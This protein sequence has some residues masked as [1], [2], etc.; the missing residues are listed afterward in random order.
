MALVVGVLGP[1]TIEND[2]DPVGKLPKK[3]RALLAYLADH[4]GR[5]VSRERLAD[6]LWPYQASDQARHS[7]RNCLLELRKELGPSATRHLNADFSTCSLDAADVDLD[8]FERLS[9]SVQRAELQAAADLYRGELLADFVIDSEPFQEWLAVERDRTLELVC[10]ILQRLIAAQDA[11]GLHDAAIRSARRLVAFDQLSEVGQRALI[12]AYARAGRRPE[13]LRQY[14]SCIE[15]LKRELGVAPDAETQ[16]LANEITRSGNAVVPPVPGR[17][18]PPVAGEIAAA[19]EPVPRAV[20]RFATQWSGAARAKPSWPCVLPSIGV[21][22]APMRNLTGDPD[23]QYLVD[24]FTEDLVTD[25]LRHGRS[26]ALGRLSNDHRTVDGLGNPGEPE[27]EYVVS[28]SVQRSGPRTLRVNMQIADAGTVRYRWGGRYE[29]NPDDLASVQTKITRQIS[30]ELHL[31]V[32]QE[33]SRRNFAANGEEIGVNEC[34]ARAAAAFKG[35]IIPELTAEAQNW[36]LGALARDPRNVEALTGLA[37]TC[38]HVVSNPWW[39]D[40]RAVS[41]SS[42]L[43]RELIGLALALAPGR[44]DAHCI[45]GMLR[46]A[47]GQLEE[48]A[49]SF[50]RAL[51]IDQRLGIAHGFAGY[52]AALL[53][54]AER[55]MA[56]VERAMQCD[57][58]DRR[59]SIFCFYGGFA[60]LLLGR[61]EAAIALLEKSLERNPSFGAAQLFLIAALSLTG[62][63]AEA[64]RMAQ[65]FR[66]QYPEYRENAFEQQWLSRSA[67]PIYRAQIDPVF[68]SIRGLELGG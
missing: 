64:G 43:G 3:A 4:R 18:G 20:D 34:L 10:G 5:P 49:R 25:L 30:R 54:H 2:G 57:Q 51:T 29:I 44:A 28:G 15:I 23:Q 33:A 19:A 8:R 66:G 7:L 68:E 41:V 42:D 14:R 32:I 13:A 50:E 35:N 61:G 31:L 21:G 62:R 67:S 37:F 16:A 1:L 65:S 39:G 12:R 48:A 11:A 55:T 27:T 46:S 56:S 40:P 45:Q 6:L 24:G 63:C 52:N 26:L 58:S 22:V 47:A 59:H 17:T 36:L 38:Q 60:E 9:H 53:G